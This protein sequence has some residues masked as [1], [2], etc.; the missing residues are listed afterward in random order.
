VTKPGGHDMHR[1]TSGKQRRRMQVTQIVQ[2]GVGEYLRRASGRLVVLLISLFI[3][4][5]TVSG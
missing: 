5:D 3:S 4:A 1:N 2:A